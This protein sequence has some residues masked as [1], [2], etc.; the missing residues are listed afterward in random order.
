VSRERA[1]RRAVREA[2]LAV[3]RAKRA[4]LV[5]RRDRRRALARRLRPRLP[6]RRTG[7]LF[8]R[9]TPA[10]RAAVAAVTVAAVGLIWLK[11]DSLETRIALTVVV[12]VAL[13]VFVVLVFDRR[14]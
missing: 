10:Q 14:I 11:I 5:A 9:R 1:Q 12:G 13:P 4:R 3:V 7:R 2:E 6:D 8:A